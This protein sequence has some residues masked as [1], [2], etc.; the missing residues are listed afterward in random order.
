MT[1]PLRRLFASVCY[2]NL[3][4]TLKRH[5]LLETFAENIMI[6]Q[7]WFKKFSF[8]ETFEDEPRSG[9]MSVTSDEELETL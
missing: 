8:A 9:R 7:N 3:N 4:L 1:I 6:A 5:K 2:K